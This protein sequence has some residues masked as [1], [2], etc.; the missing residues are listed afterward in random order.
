MDIDSK[1]RTE[2][3]PE[4]MDLQG[5]Q[6]YAS[7]S[8]RTLRKWLHRSTNPLP[9]VRVGTKILIWTEY[10]RRL[11]EIA[12]AH[13]WRQGRREQYGGRNSSGFGGEKLMGVTIRKRG[14]EGGT[15]SLT[16][17]LA[18]AGIRK[19]WLHHLRQHADLGIRDILSDHC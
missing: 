6:Q 8:D 13:S 2:L 4:W 9:A 19:V 3:G 11:V 12:S 7:V 14:K 15:S 18:K 1:L 16:T 5:V 17:V 10:T